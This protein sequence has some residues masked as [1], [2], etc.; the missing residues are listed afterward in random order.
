MRGNP[1]AAAGLQQQQQQQQL[2][3]G[4]YAAAAARQQ[5]PRPG[6]PYLPA[7]AQPLQQ[8]QVGMNALAYGMTGMRHQ[9]VQQQMQGGPYAAGG[10]QREQPTQATSGRLR[11]TPMQLA[12]MQQQR[13]QQ[14]RANQLVVTPSI[15]SVTSSNPSWSEE[16]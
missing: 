15:H 14:G 10:L 3:T 6:S 7:N 9:G 1:Y 5:Q 11:I 12:M 4:Q 13:L 8:Q 16:Q 2:N